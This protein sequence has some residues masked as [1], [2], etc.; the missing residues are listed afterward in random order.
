MLSFQLGLITIIH[1]AWYDKSANLYFSFL[2]SA[3][4]VQDCVTVHDWACF[5]FLNW[6]SG[7]ISILG[8]AASAVPYKASMLRSVLDSKYIFSTAASKFSMGF[9]LYSDNLIMRRVLY[10]GIWIK[11]HFDCPAPFLLSLLLQLVPEDVNLYLEHSP[12]LNINILFPQKGLKNVFDEAI[13]A[14]LEPPE[15]K[16]RRKC[17]LL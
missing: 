15:P 12:V 1:A 3:T 2:L 14:A 13:L 9:C 7:I 17:V 11:E 10:N 16:K 5:C 8:S 4:C 6:C